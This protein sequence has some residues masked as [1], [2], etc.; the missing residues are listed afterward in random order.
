MSDA[1][2]HTVSLVDVN[3]GARTVIVGLDG[4]AG[5]GVAN[6]SR[7]DRVLL[8]SP[9]ALARANNGN[10]YIAGVDNNQVLRRTPAGL[11]RRVLGDPDG[12][13]GTA[14][15]AKSS[16]TPLSTPGQ[17]ALDRQGNLYVAAARSARVVY[18]EDGVIDGDGPSDVIFAADGSSAL[19]ALDDATRCISGV[20][21]IDDHTVWL[22]DRCVGALL[23]LR[24]P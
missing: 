14:S 20:A 3:T 7:G 13:G 18:A 11:V 4:I 24:R 10:L 17:L 12:E 9:G 21:V 15:G 23:E 2:R 19:G 22:A 5:R 1:A 6:D 16:Q 8:S